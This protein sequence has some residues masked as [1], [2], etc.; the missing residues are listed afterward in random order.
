MVGLIISR[1]TFVAGRLVVVWLVVGW[2]VVG[3]L[4]VG[5]QSLVRNRV[6]DLIRPGYLLAVFGMSS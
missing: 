6:G 5:Q 3:R 2:L 1:V 4:V